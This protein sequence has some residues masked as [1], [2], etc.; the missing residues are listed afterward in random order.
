MIYLLD[1]FNLI[2]KFPELEENMYR[3]ELVEARRG[4]LKKMKELRGRL[5]KPPEI[6][7]FFDGKR[8]S[9]DSIQNE[10]ISEMFVYYSHEESA[11]FQIKEYVNACP[12]PGEVLVVSSDKDIIQHVKK[13]RCHSKT[14]EEFAEWV[15][16]ELSPPENKEPE[17]DANP[18][19]SE[20]E[21]GFWM[22]MFRKDKKDKN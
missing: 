20:N 5:K 14:S 3:G 1:A 2:Y 6:H 10:K 8:K 18:K 17:K 7:L 22:E 11:D 13:H 9:G 12:S 21:V 15:N 4:L 16:R 19:V